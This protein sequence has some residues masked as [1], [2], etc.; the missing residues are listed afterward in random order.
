MYMYTYMYM[1]MYMYTRDHTQY[2]L[3]YYCLAGIQNIQSMNSSVVGRVRVTMAL[4][5]FCLFAT[6][7]NAVTTEAADPLFDSAPVTG[8]F[9]NDNVDVTSDSGIT[10]D[11]NYT[12]D[13]K[14][15]IGAVT[16]T[17]TVAETTAS[18]GMGARSVG[19]LVGFVAA[20]VCLS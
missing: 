4:V 8:G 19:A 16:T 15:D 7:A 1:Y 20:A 13:E 10:L 14:V 2:L 5:L 11:G 3:P 18:S 17:P 6:L 9:F 12:G